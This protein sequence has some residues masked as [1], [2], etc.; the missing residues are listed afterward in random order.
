MCTQI[1]KLR[2]ASVSAH[3]RYSRQLRLDLEVLEEELTPAAVQPSDKWLVSVRESN[4][5]ALA[6]PM[7]LLDRSMPDREVQIAPQARPRSPTA[8]A[9]AAIRIV[10]TC[11]PVEHDPECGGN[12]AIRFVDRPMNRDRTKDDTGI[13]PRVEW[14]CERSQAL[15]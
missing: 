13:A 4:M 9:S 6:G 12:N 15:L 2:W 14:S 3:G 10:R 7:M 1:S 11:S 8:P 5:C